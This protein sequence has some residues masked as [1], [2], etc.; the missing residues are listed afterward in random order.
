MAE[1]QPLLEAIQAS[2]RPAISATGVSAAAD[3]PAIR[4]YQIVE[5]LLAEERG[6]AGRRPRPRR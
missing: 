4:A 5:R 1:D 3:A 6:A 2:A